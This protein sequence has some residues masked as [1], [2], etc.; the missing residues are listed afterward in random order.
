MLAKLL[1]YRDLEA[2]AVV[3]SWATLKNLIEQHGFPPGRLIGASRVWTEDEVDAWFASR[4]TVNP[5]APRG[6]AK[7]GYDGPRGPRKVPP[8][9]PPAAMVELAAPPKRGRPRKSPLIG[10]NPA[11]ATP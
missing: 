6:C 7:K 11:P 4:P 2:K 10:G 8:Q 9:P 1:R 3:A 5:D